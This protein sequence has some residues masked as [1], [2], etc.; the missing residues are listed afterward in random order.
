MLTGAQL[1]TAISAVLAAAVVLGWILHWL[2]VRLSNAAISDTA[3]ITEMINRLHEADRAREAAEDAKELA[4]NLLASREAE[5]ENRLA[6]MQAR[7]DGAVEGRE[8][9]LSAELREAKA[10][11]E[12]SMAG[13][14][15][16]RARIMDLEAE[17]EDLRR[18][19]P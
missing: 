10:D 3:R 9:D 15:N 6:A 19:M 11:S 2:W 17:I 8:A 4:E 16:A 5:M 18:E 14:R 7:M 13:L 1:A 12:A